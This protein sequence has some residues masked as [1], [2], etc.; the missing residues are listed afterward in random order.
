VLL[1]ELVAFS[2][3]TSTLAEPNTLAGNGLR[4]QGLTC[5]IQLSV[6]R[7]ASAETGPMM[8]VSSRACARRACTAGQYAPCGLHAD[9]MS[10]S[11]LRPR[12]Q[13]S[14]AIGAALDADPK[15]RHSLRRG[16]GHERQVDRAMRLIHKGAIDKGSVQNLATR[17]GVG[18]RH[19]SRL[20]QKHVG[21]RPIEVAKTVR[22]Q[23]A[24]RLPP[25]AKSMA[26]SH[27]TLRP[28][29]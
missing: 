20:F 5:W 27:S 19:L 17:L 7:L 14:P 13:R 18:A 26:R 25:P 3:L 11:F 15:Q 12:L 6:S 28:L 9:A 23:R 16:E 22:V 24:E 4:P 2:R 21:A 8:A 10:S 1:P 29:P